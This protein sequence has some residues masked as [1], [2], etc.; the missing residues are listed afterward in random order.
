M[1]VKEAAERMGVTKWALYKMIKEQRGI[2]AKFEY[3]GP[4]KGYFISAK[5]VKGKK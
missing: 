4:A 2:G 1:T 3:R 5:Y